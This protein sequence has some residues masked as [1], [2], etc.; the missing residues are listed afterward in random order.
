MSRVSL[1]AAALAAIMLLAGCGTAAGSGPFENHDSPNGI[2]EPVLNRDMAMTQGGQWAFT[3]TGPAAVIDRISLSRPRG[4]RIVDAWVITGQ[5]LYGNYDGYPSPSQLWNPQVR[6][7]WSH[8]QRAVGARISRT[9]HSDVIDLVVVIKL[10]AKTGSTNGFDVWY[11]TRSAHYHL[12]MIDT[13]LAW[14]RGVK[15]PKCN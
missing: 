11:H 3:S 12:H 10:V 9:H 2:C 7:E 1:A 14:A 4:L 6:A 5:Y 8:R 13:V 15:P